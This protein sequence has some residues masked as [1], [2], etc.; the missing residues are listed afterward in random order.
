LK[1]TFLGTRAHIEPEK[2][3]HRMHTST[4]V[5]YRGR[6]VMIDCGETWRGHLE[7]IGPDAIVLT[8]AHA[9]HVGGLDP[10]LYC[11]IYGTEETLSAVARQ[12]IDGRS[13]ALRQH[14]LIEG[15]GFEAFPVV[16]SVRAPAVGYRIN[17]GRTTIFYAPDVLEIP[18]LAGAFADITAYVGD[19]SSVVR[20]IVRRAKPS[21]E[22]I[23]HASIQTQLDWCR[24]Q[25][26]RRMIV[27]HCG[28]GIVGADERVVGARVRALGRE[29]G[30]EVDIAHDG[31]ERVLG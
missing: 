5:S 12:G 7:A 22:P 16:H 3:R 8:H 31:M 26:V 30:V 25:G 24:E 1:L 4:L 2:R 28:S 6:N 9:D 17:A 27:T 20:P 10:D 29:R 15:I 19:G 23:G 11:P 18:E 13:L 21:G 14:V